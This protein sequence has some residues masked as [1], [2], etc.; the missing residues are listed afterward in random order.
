MK[1]VAMC[2]AD[3][4]KRFPTES[5]CL[6]YEQMCSDVAAANNMLSNGATLMAALIR[7]NQ[8]RPWWD[9]SLNAEDKA[10]LMRITK[11]TGFAVC[12]WQLSNKP[13][14]KPCEI[15]SEG[16]VHLFGDAGGWSGPYGGWVTV[17]DLLRY[18]RGG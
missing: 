10:L 11:E 9:E 1:I 6:N 5:G 17:R 15:N 14:Y 3:D 4:G 2:E 8:T 16:S 13:A 18:A 7:A 12:H